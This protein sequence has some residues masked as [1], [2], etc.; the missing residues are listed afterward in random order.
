VKAETRK[1]EN[2]ESLKLGSL[3]S[4]S[5]RQRTRNR[6]AR[7]GRLRKARAERGLDAELSQNPRSSNKVG[8]R[9]TRK[10]K[11]IKAL[12]CPGLILLTLTYLGFPI[13]LHFSSF[14]SNSQVAAT[15]RAQAPINQ[16]ISRRP[17]SSIQC[18]VTVAN[19][20]KLCETL[21]KGGYRI[22]CEDVEHHQL[23]MLSI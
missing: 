2:W 4:R 7:T 17:I 12:M 14:R 15:L 8:P 23:P 21:D 9:I 10:K 19:P 20:K 11:Q 16:S 3:Y 1:F 13:S 5:L 6:E 22:V 18:T